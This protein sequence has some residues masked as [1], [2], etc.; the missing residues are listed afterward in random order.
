MNL[1]PI[2][3]DVEAA[4]TRKEKRTALV[5]AKTVIETLHELGYDLTKKHSIYL[6]RLNNGFYAAVCDDP[7][8]YIEGNTM[9]VAIDAALIKLD[10]HNREKKA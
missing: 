5:H 1:K 8:I 2:I 10:A 6:K 4:L 7:A 9:Q 3:E